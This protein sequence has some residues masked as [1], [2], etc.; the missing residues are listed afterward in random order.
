[1]GKR[2]LGEGGAMVAFF[3]ARDATPE[4]RAEVVEMLFEIE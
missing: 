4:H 2:L 3:T 1:L